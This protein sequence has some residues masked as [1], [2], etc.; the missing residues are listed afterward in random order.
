MV[1]RRRPMHRV[2]R[3]EFDGLE[4]WH[5]LYF[6]LKILSRLFLFSP[7]L[8]LS[9]IPSVQ[10]ALSPCTCQFISFVKRIANIFQLIS[11]LKTIIVSY[12]L[13]I[14]YFTVTLRF[15][16]LLGS[17]TSD[18]YFMLHC[19][20]YDLLFTAAGVYATEATVEIQLGSGRDF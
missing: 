10:R 11:D 1:D 5:I 15:L 14:K 20:F 12:C 13:L 8:S 17:S 18:S 9:F 2:L 4:T 6:K 7:L 3:I 16:S 19:F